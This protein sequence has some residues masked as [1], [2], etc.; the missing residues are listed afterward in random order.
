MAHG[1]D[2]TCTSCVRGG[3]PHMTLLPQQTS[4]CGAARLINSVL[5]WQSG[6]WALLNRTMNGGKEFRASHVVCMRRAAMGGFNAPHCIRPSFE[7]HTF[8]SVVWW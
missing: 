7:T 2:N 4:G 6:E 3:S 8:A 5:V 1:I